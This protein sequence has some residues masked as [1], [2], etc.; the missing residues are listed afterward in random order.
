[1]EAENQPNYDIGARI[2]EEREI[3]VNA[4]MAVEL[5]EAL[6]PAILFLT[7]N[8]NE[9]SRT[10]DDFFSLGAEHGERK[11]G[12]HLRRSMQTDSQ[13]VE[14]EHEAERGAR[15]QTDTRVGRPHLVGPA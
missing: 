12:Q 10:F 6:I 15:W 3:R 1:M 13:G 14:Q 5:A 4:G 8:T 11:E 2:K 9:S 7:T